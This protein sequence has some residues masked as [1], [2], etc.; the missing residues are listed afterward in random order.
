MSLPTPPMSPPKPPPLRFIAALLS[1][2]VPGLGQIL[3]GLVAGNPRRFWKG[4]FFCVSL[5]GMFF[6]GQ[7]LG[8]WRNVYLAHYQEEMIHAER[9]GEAKQALRWPWGSV[10]APLAGDLRARWTYL[11]QFW[12]GLAAWPAL[13]NYYLPDQPIFGTYQA[14]PGALRKDDQRDRREL[15]AEADQLDSDLQ[16]GPGMG[17]IFDVAWMYTCIAGI[18]NLL[19]IYDAWA[20]P[21]RLVPEKKKEA[22]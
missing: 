9:R 3:Q 2:T 22:R 18:M 5:L 8:A 7:W 13:W 15:L 20:G 12:I 10:M 4:V 1:F 21:V 14:S 6:Y 11:G 19:V 17:R 16:F